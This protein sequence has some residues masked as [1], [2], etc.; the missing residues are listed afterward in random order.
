MK[1]I[2]LDRILITIIWLVYLA[3]HAGLLFNHSGDILIFNQQMPAFITIENIGWLMVN[4]LLVALTWTIIREAFVTKGQRDL[5]RL[6]IRPFMLQSLIFVLIW[7][8]A[9]FN[10]MD[11][12]Y[13]LVS[14]LLMTTL[15]NTIR[16][17]S[18]KVQL[19]Q[20]KWL[21]FPLGLAFGSAIAMMFMSLALFTNVTITPLAEFWFTLLLIVAMI[22]VSVYSY[23]KYGNEMIM[24]PTT[25]YLLGLVIRWW[26][27]DFDILIIAILGFVISLG[28]YIYILYLQRKEQIDK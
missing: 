17:I 25:A 15:L 21:K 4:G 13:F 14:A 22:A 8:I 24:L 16:L 3:C 27:Q 10:G 7:I 20:Q 23:V 9:W 11:L 5:Y 12:V 6:Y 19:R 26:G 18:G 2:W 28:L 1:N